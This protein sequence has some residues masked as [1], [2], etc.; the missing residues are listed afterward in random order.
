MNIQQCHYSKDDNQNLGNTSSMTVAQVA[1][2]Y[3]IT[4]EKAKRI[5]LYDIFGG[6]VQLLYDMFGASSSEQQVVG[7]MKNRGGKGDPA[8]DGATAGGQPEMPVADPSAEAFQNISPYIAGTQNNN[9]KIVKQNLRK[10]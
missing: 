1:D 8:N 10:K 9:T 7:S 5:I 2:F 4:V 6:K 3:K